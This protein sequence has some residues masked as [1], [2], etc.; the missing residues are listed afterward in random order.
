MAHALRRYVVDE[1][2]ELLSEGEGPFGLHLKSEGCTQGSS[3]RDGGPFSAFV[4]AVACAA[5]MRPPPLPLPTR[6]ELQTMLRERQ[7]E[8]AAAEKNEHSSGES[9]INRHRDAAVLADA[10]Y[11]AVQRD[12]PTWMDLDGKESDDSD[13]EGSYFDHL[14]NDSSTGEREDGSDASIIRDLRRKFRRIPTLCALDLDPRG[15]LISG[16]TAP[17]TFQ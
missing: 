3:R 10:S 16:Q 15:T 1:R 11:D 13:R 4:D 14:P 2:G 9:E 12:R 8:A 5:G 6:E 7:G 17:I